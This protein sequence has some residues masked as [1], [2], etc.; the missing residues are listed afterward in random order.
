MK[1]HTGAEFLFAKAGLCPKGF[2]DIQLQDAP[3]DFHNLLDTCPMQTYLL[4]DFSI[5]HA[6]LA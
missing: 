4:S 1:L 2:D 3:F 6:L 5:V